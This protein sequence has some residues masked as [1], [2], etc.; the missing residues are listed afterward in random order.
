MEKGEHYSIADGIANLYTHCGNQ[1]GRVLFFP[2]NWK[3]FYLNSQLYPKDASPCHK[4]MCSTMFVAALFVI[5]RNWK[6]P[7][8]SLIEKLI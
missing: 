4:G 2:E 5:T 7:R 3:Y 6:Q 1:S 8:C